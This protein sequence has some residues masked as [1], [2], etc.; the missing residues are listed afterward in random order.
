VI[1]IEVVSGGRRL[2]AYRVSDPLGH[3]SVV[4]PEAKEEYQIRLHNSSGRTVAVRMF[5]DGREQRPGIVGV[6]PWQLVPDERKVIPPTH[7][8]WGTACKI[9]AT[10]RWHCLYDPKVIAVELWPWETLE[11]KLREDYPDVESFPRFDD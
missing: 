9:S 1:K 8:F 2:K 10:V 4:G 7:C 5:R 6:Y 11:K 3:R